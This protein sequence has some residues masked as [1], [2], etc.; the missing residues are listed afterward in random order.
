MQLLNEGV[1]NIMKKTGLWTGL[2][3]MCMCMTFVCVFVGCGEE[4]DVDGNELKS[5]HCD[6]DGIV[7][8]TKS[9]DSAGNVIK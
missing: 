6:A 2:V 1:K 3:V 7:I 8:T 5:V 4:M 9:Y